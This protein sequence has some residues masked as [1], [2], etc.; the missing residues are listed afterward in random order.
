[1]GWGLSVDVQLPGYETRLAIVQE[2]AALLKLILPTDV[3]EFIATNVRRNL[4]ELENI[5]N[6][7]DAEVELNQV[8]PT[9]QNVGK[10]FRKLN[11]SE[12]ILAARTNAGASL[13]KCT[14]DVITIISEYFQ[15]PATELLGE[16][17]KR[18]FVFPRQVAWLLCKEVLNMSFE[19]I[20]TDFGGKNHTTI[21]YGIRKI[22]DLSRSDSATAR[23]IHALR[24]D[25]GM[26]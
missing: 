4:R 1:M 15:I 26:K 19:A 13:A 12:D 7:I 20:G 9:V 5:L 22:K 24:K 16:S 8:S 18:E 3:Q 2:K 21:M 23:H 6:Q 10:I 25:L 17:R 14:D 11:P